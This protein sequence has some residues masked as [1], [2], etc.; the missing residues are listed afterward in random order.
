M[1]ISFPFALEHE[2]EV[3]TADDDAH[4]RQMIEQVLF[5]NPGERVNRPEL[6]CGLYAMVFEPMSSEMVAV[7]EALVRT[8]LLTWLGDLISVERLAVEAVESTLEVT[9]DYAVLGTG[10]RRT[11]TFIR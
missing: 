1:Q 6:G 2:G 5:T 7:T 10:E 4:I 8:N 3:A 11:G 9:I